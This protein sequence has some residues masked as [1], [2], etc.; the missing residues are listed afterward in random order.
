MAEPENLISKVRE[1]VEEFMSHY[2]GSH[3]FCHVKRVLGLS[4][5]IYDELSSD[6]S[7]ASSTSAQPLDPLVI[8]LAALLHD[9]GDKKYLREGEDHRTLAHT[10]LVSLGASPALAQKVQV[11]CLGVSYSSEIQDLNYVKNLIVQHPELSVVQDADRLDALGAVGVGRVFT[12]GGAK[13]ERSM[14]E[15]MQIME[16][17]L[18]KLEGMMKTGPGKRMAREKT[19]RLRMFRQWWDEECRVEQ[20]GSS[21]L[22][23]ATD[24]QRKFPR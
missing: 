15:S 6:F 12:F 2:D 22:S 5:Q 9:V 13:V 3:D 21:V 11:I 16:K 23:A 7:N 8:T 17:K 4:H 24:E 19:E 10:L 20:S 14:D 1:Y 18:F